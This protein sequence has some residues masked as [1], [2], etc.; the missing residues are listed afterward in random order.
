MLAPGR[1]ESGGY[2]I[3]EISAIRR[4]RVK[5]QVVKKPKVFWTR[6]RVLCILAGGRSQETFEMSVGERELVI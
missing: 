1:E 2:G 4:A 6:L 3:R 5:A